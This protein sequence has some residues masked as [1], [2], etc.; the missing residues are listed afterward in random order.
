[1]ILSIESFKI[2]NYYFTS[3]ARAGWWLHLQLQY[4]HAIEAQT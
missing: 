3:G 2:S 1:M 4:D